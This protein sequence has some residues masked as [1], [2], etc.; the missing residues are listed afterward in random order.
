MMDDDDD[1][2]GEGYDVS[3]KEKKSELIIPVQ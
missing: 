1:G 2:K 3:I